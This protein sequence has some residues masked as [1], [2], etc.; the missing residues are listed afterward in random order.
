MS[1]EPQNNP[2]F[3]VLDTAFLLQEFKDRKW[4]IVRFTI[5]LAALALVFTL[6]PHYP[7]V[8]TT[9]RV[10]PPAG[11]SLSIGNMHNVDTE[12]GSI[13]SYSM[14]SEALKRAQYY[15][16]VTP[17]SVTEA[18]SR[19]RAQDDKPGA[20]HFDQLYFPKAMEGREWVIEILANNR[21][22][23]KTKTAKLIAEAAIGEIITGTAE[24]QTQSDGNGRYRIQV[25]AIE[26][27]AG[28]RFAVK[29]MSAEGLSGLIL[30]K[31]TV[32]KRN[33]GPGSNLLDIR[34]SLP[35][36]TLAYHLV[37]YI[38]QHYIVQS[39]ERQSAAQTQAITKLE[40][41]LAELKQDVEDGKQALLNFYKQTQAAAPELELRN[42]IPK[43]SELQARLQEAEVR[44]TQLQLIYTPRHP[45][46]Q[47]VKEEL[48]LLSGRLSDT[49]EIIAELPMQQST[50]DQLERELAINTDLYQTA[51]KE[52]ARMQLETNS[53]PQTVHLIDTPRVQAPGRTKYIIQ[54]LI[55]GGMLGFIS[56]LA[57]VLLT[58][59]VRLGRLHSLAQLTA[60]TR[61]PV[62]Q[63]LFRL[64]RGMP[65][66]AT[67]RRLHQLAQYSLHHRAPLWVG[68][69]AARQSEETARLSLELAHALAKDKQTLIIDAHFYYS[70][71]TPIMGGHSKLGLSELLI[72]KATLA[73]TVQSTSHAKLHYIPC[74]Q[75]LAD[76]DLLRDITPL[77]EALAAQPYEVIIMLLPH[78]KALPDAPKLLNG[79]SRLLHWVK[80][81]Q[82]LEQI[83]R[84]LNLFEAVDHPAH[85]VFVYQDESAGKKRQRRRRKSDKRMG[86]AVKRPKPKA[87]PSYAKASSKK[88][89]PSRAFVD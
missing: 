66:E 39:M 41:S 72:G 50:L 73:Q 17:I 29:P 52:L 59:S 40:S 46:V 16:L 34:L 64:R 6:K 60:L 12:I 27:E 38:A 87:P 85:S 42:L 62:N 76:Y 69:C 51:I 5:T 65:D 88:R 36:V 86:A 61:F 70:P 79:F 48:A 45:A 67:Q 81:G 10:D 15:A 57:I 74:G 3:G 7:T 56:S 9:L 31:L 55:F 37:E 43:R 32:T 30:S 63:T 28:S 19:E 1:K 82:T 11:R 77:R 80:I 18:P 25:R 75:K 68:M 78:P 26:A 58:A 13:K 14:V 24:K 84:Y 54:L 53:L 20:L 89:G 4:L 8:K 83:Q 49:K 44:L 71:L 33:S 22:A 35:D 23:L 47:A 2:D 21:Y